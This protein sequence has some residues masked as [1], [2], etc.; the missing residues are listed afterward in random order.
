MSGENVVALTSSIF[1]LQQQTQEFAGKRWHLDAT[2]PPMKRP[3]AEEWN[4]FF[5]GLHG[6]AGTF[7]FGDPNGKAPRGSALGSPV[8]DGAAQV[9][10][11]LATKGW[12]AD[13]TGVLLSGDYIRL[14]TGASARLHK[15]LVQADSDGSGEVTLDIWPNLRESPGDSQTIFL[16]D[17]VSVFRLSSNITQWDLNVAAFY[18]FAFSAEEAI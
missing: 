17:T 15:V 13:E 14:G 10:V 16:D 8:V 5:L 2:F 7:L 3:D 9:G 18:G 12:T 4:A 11:T 1:T 6:R